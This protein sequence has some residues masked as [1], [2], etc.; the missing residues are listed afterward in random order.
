MREHCQALLTS[1]DH[2]DAIKKL[3]LGLNLIALTLSSGGDAT[4][5]SF[6]GFCKVPKPRFKAILPPILLAV[7]PNVDPNILKPS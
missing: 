5:T 4:S 1:F 6:I 7:L 2:E 3:A